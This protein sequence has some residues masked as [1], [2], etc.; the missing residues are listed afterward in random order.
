MKD[1]LLAVAGAGRDD[2]EKLNL[3]RE[4]LQRW[5]L[6]IIFN[7][8]MFE[9]L[10]FI[11]GTALRILYNLRRFSED[12]DFSLIKS[13]GYSF[14]KLSKEIIQELRLN[15]LETEHAH[16]EKNTVNSGFLKFPGLLKELS[17][18]PLAGQK[19]S[20]KLEVDVRPP[21]GGV[22]Q[23]TPVTGE[24]LTVIQHYD[25]PSLFAGKLHALFFRPYTKGRDIYDLIWYLGKKV[26]PNYL[27]LNNA[28]KQ[29][30]DNHPEISSDNMKV[31]MRERFEKIDMAK[32]RADVGRF[33]EDENELKLFDKKLILGMI[34]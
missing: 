17:L 12:M 9:H 27:F 2:R 26:K 25:L 24:Y 22:I 14:S 28:I 8:G 10:V 29:T 11:G 31:F 23:V 18:S 7:K 5:I 34:E 13:K 20:I 21:K 19:L 1:T 3:A 16:K 4:Y 32:A 30:R 33:L 6:R 15:G